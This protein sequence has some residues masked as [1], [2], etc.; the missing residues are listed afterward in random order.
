MEGHSSPRR[1][2]RS[3]TLSD[4]AGF[5]GDQYSYLSTRFAIGSG[6]VIFNITRANVRRSQ[7]LRAM[8]LSYGSAG[9]AIHLRSRALAAIAS[10]KTRPAWPASKVGNGRGAFISPRSIYA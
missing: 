10:H 8:T 7:I 3:V 2:C 9:T 6:L 1:D 5:I 4:T